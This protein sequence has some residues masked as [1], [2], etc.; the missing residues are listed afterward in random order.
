[1]LIPSR[2]VQMVDLPT[3]G[4]GKGVDDGGGGYHGN[5]DQEMGMGGYGNG[6][7]AVNV[8]GAYYGYAVMAVA[9]PV[10][11]S[12]HMLGASAPPL[13]YAGAK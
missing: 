11:D 8:G 4:V 13:S 9:V 7:Q 2:D 5:R 12:S 1:M 10:E 3:S 6:V